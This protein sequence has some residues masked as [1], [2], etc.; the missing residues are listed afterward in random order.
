MSL[1]N[2]KKMLYKEN[3]KIILL[4]NSVQKKSLLN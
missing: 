1:E 2:I 4:I 3:N